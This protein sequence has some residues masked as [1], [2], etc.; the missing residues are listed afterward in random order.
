MVKHLFFLLILA[1]LGSAS[2][3]AAMELPGEACQLGSDVPD[4]QAEVLVFS[5]HP[6]RVSEDG[7][8]CQGGLLP[9]RPV[10]WQFYHQGGRQEPLYLVLRLRNR[11]S[12]NAV[13]SAVGGAGLGTE[14]NYFQAGHDNNLEFMG[15]LLSGRGHLLEVPPGETATVWTQKLPCDIVASGTVQWCLLAGQ[16]TE[17]CLYSCSS[18]EGPFYGNLLFNRQDVH[19]RGIYPETERRRISQLD[20][21][22]WQNEKDQAFWAI[23]AT[24]QPSAFSGP[25]LKGD[26]G[27]LYRWDLRLRNSSDKAKCLEFA[28]NPRGGKATGT[29]MVLR[30]GEYEQWECR[31]ELDAFKLQ[32]LAVLTVPPHSDED[33]VIYTMPEGASNYPVRL[34]VR[35]ADTKAIDAAQ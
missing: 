18:P 19:A 9:L 15:N 14:E 16:D 6:E 30:R 34:V 27:V 32:R 4:A 29:F 8:L 25:A 35:L 10:R 31:D 1:A 22:S 11:G 3:N 12:R 26:Y 24:R 33:L 2:A 5:D 23:G 20:I 21:S 7:L 17:Y 13:V 28:L